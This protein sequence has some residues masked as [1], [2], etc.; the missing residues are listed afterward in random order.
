V[1][2]RTGQPQSIERVRTAFAAWRETAWT[3]LRVDDLKHSVAVD[4]QPAEETRLA[5]SDALLL[6]L[7]T[8]G[9]QPEDGF[10]PIQA[11]YGFGVHGTPIASHFREQKS[12]QGG[13][14]EASPLA[15][16]H[17]HSMGLWVTTVPLVRKIPTE[18]VTD[19][20]RCGVRFSE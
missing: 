1:I 3:E 17:T 18:T 15:C 8:Q 10:G 11:S 5:D 19:A 14:V 12:K 2:E 4:L 9:N 16:A 7:W 13:V 6:I 20:M